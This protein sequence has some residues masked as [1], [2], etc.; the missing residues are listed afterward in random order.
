M[1]NRSNLAVA[2]SFDNPVISPVS[3]SIWTRAAEDFAFLPRALRAGGV[4][5]S[6][7]GGLRAARH[8]VEFRHAFDQV[9]FDRTPEA[10]SV[11]RGLNGLRPFW[12]L[13][14]T[15][16]SVFSM[17]RWNPAR[18]ALQFAQREK[19]VCIVATR[20]EAAREA[21]VSLACS[22]HTRL[23]CRSVRRTTPLPP[24]PS[25]HPQDDHR[26][27]PNDPHGRGKLAEMGSQS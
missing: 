12:S 18:I 27:Q 23:T 2:G 8:N 25:Q 19:R 10:R 4:W 14:T 5:A 11:F 7:I 15:R 26:Q 9:V 20:T 21:G 16:V 1:A 13:L 17:T 6:L 22:H 3:G 24:S